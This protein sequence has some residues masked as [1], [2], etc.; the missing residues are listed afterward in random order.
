MTRL[1]TICARA[2]SHEVSN[3]NIR[4]LAGKPLFAHTLHQAIESTLFDCVAF[5]SDSEDY[6]ALARDH[7]APLRIRRPDE[8]ATETSS[9]LDAIIHAVQ[10]AERNMGVKFDVIVDLDVTSPLRAAADIEAVVSML[11]SSDV[12]N[13][14]TAAPARRSPY[15]NLIEKDCGGHVRL[16]KPSKT[17]VNRRQASPECFDMNAS[18]YAWRRDALMDDPQVFYPDTALY[19]MPQERSLDID[20]ELDFEIVEFLMART[21]RQGQGAE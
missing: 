20:S 14:I 5:S 21:E 10:D 4:V 16:C 2:G 1:C 11:E 3:K 9:K 8:F 19:V 15:F 7:G 17:I 6:L 13:V 12:S 18:I